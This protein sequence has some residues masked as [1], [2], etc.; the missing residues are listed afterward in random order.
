MEYKSC[1][2]YTDMKKL[3]GLNQE[4]KYPI[5]SS[6]IRL[7]QRLLKLMRPSQLERD[8]ELAGLTASEM[9]LNCSKVCWSSETR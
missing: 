5:I 4:H 7:P 2:D 1:R 6:L 9:Y 3:L 8:N